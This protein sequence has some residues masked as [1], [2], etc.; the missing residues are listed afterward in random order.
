MSLFA[1]TGCYGL[2]VL[3]LALPSSDTPVKGSDVQK[4]ITADLEAGQPIVAHVVVALCDNKQ[5]GI[6]RVRP[7]LGNGQDPKNNLYWGALYGVK[8]YLTKR[9]GWRSVAAPD[10]AEKR[11]LDRAIFHRIVLRNG[12]QRDVYVVADAWDGKEIKAA[13]HRFLGYS[14]G[15][16]PEHIPIKHGDKNLVLQAGADAHLIAYVGHNGLMD[17]A[18]PE[19]RQPR[20]GAKSRSAIILACMS[21][22]FFTKHLA[23]AHAHAL[24]LTTGLM[25]PEAYTLDAALKS[26][27][28]DKSSATVHEAA[29]A[30]YH[31]FQKCGLRAARR[32]FRASP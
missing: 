7:A 4:R 2:S 12:R 8:T 27:F 3:L 9:G 5:Q 18:A 10:Q 14:A 16:E 25:A 31:R 1:G 28:A 6:V 32:L 24:L 11:I 15:F 20:A 22:P 30:A 19:P 13:T 23:A 26:W 17:F 21:K 29:A